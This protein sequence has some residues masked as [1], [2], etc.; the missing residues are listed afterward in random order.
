MHVFDRRT[1]GR[2]NGQTDVDR[3]TVRMLRSRTVKIMT[4]DDGVTDDD[5]DDNVY[6]VSLF[7]DFFLKFTFCRVLSEHRMLRVSVKRESSSRRRNSGV[8]SR[9]ESSTAMKNRPASCRISRFQSK[10]SWM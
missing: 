4:F 1:D 6:V 3:K 5:Y 8:L 2:T 7:F 10:V 9:T